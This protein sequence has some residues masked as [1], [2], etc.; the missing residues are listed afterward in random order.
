MPAPAKTPTEAVLG[1]GTTIEFL[2][3]GFLSRGTNFRGSRGQVDAV[4]VTNFDSPPPEGDR[5]W[6]GEEFFA[7]SI[8]DPGQMSMTLVF[9]PG[10][11]LPPLGVED[12]IRITLP[13]KTG[14]KTP[15]TWS[16]LG[17]LMSADVSADTKTA[18]TADVVI[19]RSGVW[20]ET[21]ATK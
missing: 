9:T 5:E 4:P 14:W 1:Y 16:G 21:A 18:Y 11:K 2:S 8:G 15:T 20:T 3:F 19:Q 6:G 12:T 13:L 17:F 10:L 7:N